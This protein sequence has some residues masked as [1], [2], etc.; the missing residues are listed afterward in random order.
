MIFILQ[1]LEEV[2]DEQLPNYKER[3]PVA[4]DALD[5]F[6]A[7]RYTD[8]YRFA[9]VKLKITNGSSFDPRYFWALYP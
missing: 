2:V 5:V 6:I 9:W 3:E 1:L 7:H 4:K 8:Q